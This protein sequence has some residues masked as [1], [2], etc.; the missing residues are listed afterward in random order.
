M[1]FNAP[2]PGTNSSVSVAAVQTPDRKA[3]HLNTVTAEKKSVN[4]VTAE[5][6]VRIKKRVLV[7]QQNRMVNFVTS[8]MILKNIATPK[9]LERNVFNTLKFSSPRVHQIG[10]LSSQP[11]HLPRP[12]TGF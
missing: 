4:A 6:N 3:P 12:T 10:H 11:K 7:R 9:I 5:K 2:P 8:A 1:N